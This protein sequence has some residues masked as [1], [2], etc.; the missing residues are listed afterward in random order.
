MGV[1]EVEVVRDQ[2]VVKEVVEHIGGGEGGGNLPLVRG[3]DG[4]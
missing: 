3:D 2:M 1:K 4:G